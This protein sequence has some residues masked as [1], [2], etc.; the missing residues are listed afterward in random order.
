M[1]KKFQL[2][3]KNIENNQ[4]TTKE[5]E[6]E[7]TGAVI[8]YFKQYCNQKYFRIVEIIKIDEYNIEVGDRVEIINIENKAN[9]KKLTP[10]LGKLGIVVEVDPHW[11]YLYL[12]KS[13][14]TNFENNYN[15]QG[16]LWKHNNIKVL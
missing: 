6:L 13:L 10:F 15:Y 4:Y 8:E 3:V 7:K 14:D 16:Q 9:D 1:N 2:V 5:W 11:E 12:I